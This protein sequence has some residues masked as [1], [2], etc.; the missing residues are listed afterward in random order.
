MA[1]GGAIVRKT[2]FLIDLLALGLVTL[3]LAVAAL[4]PHAAIELVTDS[5]AHET[6]APPLAT[7]S[8]VG[9]NFEFSPGVRAGWNPQ[10]LARMQRE[11]V[12]LVS[13]GSPFHP[14]RDMMLLLAIAGSRY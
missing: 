2:P 14:P 1:L 8:D 6:V 11:N 3:M 7:E 12:H 9:I 10:M 13:S 5:R 4:M